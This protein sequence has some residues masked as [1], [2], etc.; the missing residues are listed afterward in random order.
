[1]K[2]APKTRDELMKDLR[3][4]HFVLGDDDISKIHSDYID[5]Y[6]EHPFAAQGDVGEKLGLRKSHIVY[7]T[8]DIKPLYQSLYKKDHVPIHGIA[9]A[10]LEAGL[11]KDLRSHHWELGTEGPTKES[12]YK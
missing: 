1:M 8:D 9:A 2:G 5:H 10:Q 11:I 4:H 7:G 12:D 6:K 3:K